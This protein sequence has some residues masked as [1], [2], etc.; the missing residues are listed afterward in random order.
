MPINTNVRSACLSKL[1]F[2][3]AGFETGA[4]SH[5]FNATQAAQ[6]SVG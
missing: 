2:F 5:Y 4:V 1:P 3:S 6:I